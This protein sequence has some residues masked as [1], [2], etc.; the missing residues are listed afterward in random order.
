MQDFSRSVE[1]DG[2]REDL[3]RAIHGPRGIPD[4]QGHRSVAPH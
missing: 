4:Y 1:A 3:L 2:I